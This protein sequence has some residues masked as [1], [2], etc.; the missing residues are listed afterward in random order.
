MLLHFRHTVLRW[1]QQE[2]NCTSLVCSKMVSWCLIYKFPDRPSDRDCSP[3]CSL[4]DLNRERHQD[5]IT[6]GLKVLRETP[7]SLFEDNTS[8][9]SFNTTVLFESSGYVTFFYHHHVLFVFVSNYKIQNNREYHLKYKISHAVVRY[10]MKCCLPSLLMSYFIF[11]LP[12]S[13]YE[14]AKHF[15]PSYVTCCVAKHDSWIW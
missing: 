9:S 14:I 15:S 12:K 7:G 2:G 13:L 3:A 1:C 4:S 8:S 5:L 6:T 10:I 11:V